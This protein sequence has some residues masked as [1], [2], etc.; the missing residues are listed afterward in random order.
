MTREELEWL[1]SLQ[2]RLTSLVGNYLWCR[3]NGKEYKSQIVSIKKLSD[4]LGVDWKVLTEWE[5]LDPFTNVNTDIETDKPLII[6]GLQVSSDTAKT[7][8][9]ETFQ[10]VDTC[11]SCGKSLE[12]KKIGAKFCGDRCRISKHNKKR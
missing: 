12:N 8:K 6:N 7:V 10:R 5:G 3:R 1:D 4:Y 9:K 11:Q 2:S